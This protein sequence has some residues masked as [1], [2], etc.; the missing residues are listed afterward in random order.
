MSNKTRDRGLLVACP[1]DDLS[2]LGK[3]VAMMILSFDADD[4]AKAVANYAQMIRQA[5]PSRIVL[6][7]EIPDH[8]PEVWQV[9]WCQLT[10]RLI[11]NRMGIEAWDKMPEADVD[12]LLLN[13]HQ[14]L[15]MAFDPES[16]RNGR[17]TV[18]SRTQAQD[19]IG[20]LQ[21]LDPKS[22]VDQLRRSESRYRLTFH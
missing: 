18:L 1:D 4:S 13:K 11:F 22:L 12:G 5:R 9:Q 16:I 3:P 6:A 14:A 2:Q 15:W 8:G 19:I 10:A 7:F 21:R 20:K 17:A